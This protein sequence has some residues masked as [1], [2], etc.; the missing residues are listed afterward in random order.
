MLKNDNFLRA[1]RREKTDYTPVWMMRQAGRYL[2]EY[3][4][5]RKNA[6][7]FLTLCKTPDLAAEVTLQ[8]IDRFNLDA[9]IL[10][11]DILVIP[12][13]MGM[14]LQFLE[15]EGPHFPNP[16]RD[17]AAIEKLADP[18]PMQELGY[19]MNAIKAINKGLDK[20][21]PLIGFTGAPWTLATY[22]VEGGGSKNFAVIKKMLYDRPDL[23]HALLTKTTDAIINYL[24]A[25]IESGVHAVQIFDTW[26]GILTPD[27]FDNFSLQYIQRIVEEIKGE[28]PIIVFAKGAGHML[29]SIAETGCDVVGVDWMADIGDVRK[30]IGGKVALQGNMDPCNLYASPDAIRRKV[31]DILAK[32]GEGSGHIFNLGHG[33]LPDI[34]VDHAKAFIDAVHEL[35]PAYHK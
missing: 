16:V 1:C 19:V 32:Y 15:G 10:F 33:I 31:A 2:P 5:T 24:K 11:S 28:V 12:E 29:E 8:P 18:D 17:A 20:R 14:E 23:L 4:A 26:G 6:G 7:D 34:P 3:L 13:A 30:R 35:S 22:M 9:A 27:D 21:V 25:Q